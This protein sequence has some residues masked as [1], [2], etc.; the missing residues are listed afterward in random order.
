MSILLTAV[1]PERSFTLTIAQD[2]VRASSVPVDSEGAILFPEQNTQAF[3]N[4]AQ[5]C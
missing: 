2:D 1:G 3:E 5:R 4:V